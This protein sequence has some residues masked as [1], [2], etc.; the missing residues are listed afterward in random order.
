[1]GQNMKK[2]TIVINKCTLRAKVLKRVF[3]GILLYKKPMPKQIAG[4][5]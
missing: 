5:V 2:N 3:S 4:T 1:M